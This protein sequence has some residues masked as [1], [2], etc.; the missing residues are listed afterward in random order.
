MQLDLRSDTLVL[1]RHGQTPDNA[2][3]LILGHRDPPLSDAG[4]EEAHRL[5]ARLRG[6]PIAAVWTSPLRRARETAEIVAA[7]LGVEPVVCAELTESARGRWEGVAV[8]LLARDEPHLHAAFVSGDPSFAFPGGESLRAQ[9]ERTRAGL[10][11]IARGALPAA[12]VAHAGTVRAALALAGRPVG[13]ESALRHGDVA[14]LLT[15]G[16][17]GLG[18]GDP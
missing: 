12:V 17:L 14:A 1:I 15:V 5:A 8:A 2:A 4:R 6:A 10:A 18:A 13:P 9:R 3:G 11:C 16:E 7:A